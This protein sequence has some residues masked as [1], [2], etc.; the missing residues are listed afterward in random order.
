MASC[1]GHPAARGQAAG[2]LGERLPAKRG[3]QRAGGN[4]FGGQRE[5]AKGRE[6]PG[7][8]RLGLCEGV[9]SGL[10]VLFERAPRQDL[11]LLP[12]GEPWLARLV[13]AS[14]PGR[15]ESERMDNESR[16]E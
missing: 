3:G 2:D 1:C 8:R 9:G 11:R 12:Q 16:T 4:G 13:H 10:E 15:V 14:E 7:G 6:R 5:K